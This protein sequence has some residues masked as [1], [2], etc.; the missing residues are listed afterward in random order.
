MTSPP[1]TLPKLPPRPQGESIEAAMYD[2]ADLLQYPVDSKGRVYD[3]RFMLPT[4]AYHLARAGVRCHPELALIKSRR[5]PPTPGIIED[6]VEW[7]SI[8]APDRIDDELA[9]ATLDDI[10]RLSPAARAEL[11]RRLGGNDPA[12]VNTETLDE[13]APWHVETRIHF[14]DEES[15]R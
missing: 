12:A 10:D 8:N 15:T 11:V 1:V 3:I 7:V 9:G 4:I 13:R 5:L 6:A 2:L 14:D